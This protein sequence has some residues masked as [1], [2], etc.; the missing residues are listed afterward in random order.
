MSLNGENLFALLLEGRTFYK[1]DPK[2][3]V[4]S[5]YLDFLKALLRTADHT[6]H[7][8]QGI[9]WGLGSF[10]NQAIYSGTLL[11]VSIAF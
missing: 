1:Q 3:R 7:P 2:V 9:C 5:P 6:G 4:L 11:V 10:L 8:I